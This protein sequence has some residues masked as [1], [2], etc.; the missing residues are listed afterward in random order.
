[1]TKRVFDSDPA[2]DAAIKA[3]AEASVAAGLNGSG[4]G[5]GKT[6]VAIKGGIDRGAKRVLIIGQPKTLE[7]WEETLDIE[8]PGTELKVCA[9][10]RFR[11]IP[12]ADAKANKAACM[13][14]EDGWY[15]VSRELFQREMWRNRTVKH[16]NGKTSQ[17]AEV[18]RSWCAKRQ[19]D[20][21]VYDEVQMAASAT[22]KSTKSLRLLRSE[23]KLAQSADWFG[24]E[25][26]N[27]FHV[28]KTL[29]KDWL[30][31]E[32]DDFIEWR[33][34]N[35]TTI[36]DHFAPDKKAISGEKWPGF[37]AASLP[38]YIRIP[39]PIKKPD[40]ERHYID[41]EPKERALY[42]ELKKNLAAEI[43]GELFVIDD[44]KTL[45]MRLR[46][47]TMGVFRPVDVMRKRRIE[48]VMVEVPGQTIA[49]DAGEPSSTVDAIR[50]IMKGHPGEPVII[51]SHSKKF[52]NKAAAD[53]GG[54]PYTGDQTDT[55]KADAERA[56]KAGE[57]N[58]LVG[59]EAMCEGLDGL[60]KRCRIAIIASRPGKNYMTGQFIG[61]VARRGQEREPQVYELVRR[62][63]LDTSMRKNGKV[64]KGVVEQA[65]MKELMLHGAKAISKK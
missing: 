39:S 44:H 6:R 20:Y 41:L 37:F 13:A 22:A 11:T 40:P 49:F 4:T 46:E 28:A 26:S 54:L 65:I 2:Q 14:G 8:L 25:I 15:F 36:Y 29:W 18:F 58:V 19:F 64:T 7:N 55:Q 12:A 60:Q 33:D 50:E 5:A 10:A 48:N 21:V 17:K 61:R 47:A 27:Q 38:L 53:L 16:R 63:T 57:T 9:N 1:M 52:A 34:E 51:V 3:I 56:F 30:D 24:G 62:E 35:C 59:T 31:S 23:F 43:A 32:Y 42:T 45:Y